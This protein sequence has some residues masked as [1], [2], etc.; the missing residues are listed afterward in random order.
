MPENSP[1]G[2]GLRSLRQRNL[3]A[4]A[5]FLMRSPEPLNLSEIAAGTGLSR[6]LIEAFVKELDQLDL[7]REAPSLVGTKGRPARRIRFNVAAGFTLG[8][9][10]GAHTCRALLTDLS[11]SAVSQAH[12]AVSPHLSARARL[13][14]AVQTAQETIKTTGIGPQQLCAIGIGT[15][16]IVDLD[17]AVVRADFVN[18]WQDAPITARFSETFDA[19][20]YVDNDTRMAAMA[21]LWSSTTF[22][23]NFLYLRLGFRPSV[24][25]VIDGKVFKGASGAAGEIGLISGSS[26]NL[27]ME[28][29]NSSPL[30]P[31]TT[32]SDQVTT[33][34]VELAQGNNPG[35][36]AAFEAQSQTIA[37]GMIMLCAA[38]DPATI[39]VGG[40]MSRS[41]ELLL[42]RLEELLGAGFFNKIPISV[43]NHGH[44]DVCLGAAF[45]ALQKFDPLDALLP[46]NTT[47]RG[48]EN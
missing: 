36:L 31:E 3:H 13:D 23:K 29:I 47:P 18:D 45:A 10:I 41:H 22:N 26:W 46:N 30:I 2:I 11:G 15:S 5:T 9:D 37:A 14:T 33:R 28:H 8:V 24:A 20:V 35:A 12:H 1:T 48:Q 7:T 4:V 16:G 17:G 27:A 34:M 6:P 44:D 19:P 42:P 25:L 40:G 21:E 43:S 38:F 32:P 39:I